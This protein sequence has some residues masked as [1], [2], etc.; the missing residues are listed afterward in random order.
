MRAKHEFE[1][2]PTFTG[3]LG[4]LEYQLAENTSGVS[5]THKANFQMVEQEYARFKEALNV[6]QTRVLKLHEALEKANI[7]YT[8]S[9]TDWKEGE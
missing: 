4:M 3:R 5:N 7:P 1:T 8:R 2:A 6:Y 9:R